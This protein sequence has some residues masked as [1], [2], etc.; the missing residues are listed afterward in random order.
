MNKKIDRTIFFISLIGFFIFA[1][2]TM[3]I[4]FIVRSTYP[5]VISQ[6]DAQM[7]W[8][9]IPFLYVAIIFLMISLIYV[10]KDLVED[11]QQK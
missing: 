1:V 7:I 8:L 3:T 4:R 2:L 9:K 6:H 11:A 5:L 10:I